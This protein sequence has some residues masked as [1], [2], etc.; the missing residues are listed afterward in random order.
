MLD[1]DLFHSND[2]DNEKNW[3]KK[4]SGHGTWIMYWQNSA[5]ENRVDLNLYA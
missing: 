2:I 3:Q 5:N 1:F 4:K